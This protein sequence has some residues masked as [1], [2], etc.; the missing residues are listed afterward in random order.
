MKNVKNIKHMLLLRGT[1]YEWVA[2]T[3]SMFIIA[4]FAAILLNLFVF[5]PYEVEGSSMEPTLQNSDRLIVFKLGKT[6]SNILNDDY[7]PDR[8]DIV[9]FNKNG[10]KDL[11]LVKRVVGLPGDT[12]SYDNG[13]IRVQNTEN[14]DGFIFEDEFDLDLAITEEFE[15]T[16]ISSGEVYVVGDNR[17]PNASLDSRS[18][19][20]SIDSDLIVGELVTRIYPLSSFK[21]F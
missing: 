8:G 16:S 7:I 21:L 11:Q 1:K 15:Q 20:G 4:I 2:S 3:L 10:S 13:K 14:P 18:S 5:Q 17:L 6:W 9:I 12:I 19:L